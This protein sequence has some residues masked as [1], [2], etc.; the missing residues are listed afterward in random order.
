MPTRIVEE[1]KPIEET[2]EI[3]TVPV[4]PTVVQQLAPQKV[5]NHAPTIITAL[6]S[7]S[8]PTKNMRI[9]SN[10]PPRV[11]QQLQQHSMMRNT[12]PSQQH[13]GVGAHSGIRMLRSRSGTSSEILSICV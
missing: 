12:V 2:T 11:K 1:S 8:H 3:K 7:N 9:T 10:L 5:I 4:T 13:Q 6:A